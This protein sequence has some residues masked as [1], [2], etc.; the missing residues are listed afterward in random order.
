MIVEWLVYGVMVSALVSLAGWVAERGARAQ[1]WPTRWVWLGAMAAS[2]TVPLMAWLV[3]SAPSEPAGVAAP[4]TY[5]L[6]TLEPLRTA[7]AG[8]SGPSVGTLVLWVWAG[9]TTFVLLAVAVMAARL[10][11]RR[12]A[13]VA[14]SVDGVKVLVSRC[15]GPAALGLIRGRV[16]VPEWA[17][18]LEPG[19][20]RLLVLHE[21]EHVRAGDPRL[22]FVG[23]LLC[24][25]VPWNLPVW[26]QRRRLRLAIEV[27]CD[28][29]VLRRSGDARS[30][31]SLL[32]EVGQRRAGLALALAEPRSMLERRIRMITRRGKA[33][34]IRASV[35]GAVAGLVLAGACETPKPTE[36]NVDESVL[37]PGSTEPAAT[38]DSA[39]RLFRETQRIREARGTA[40][41]PPCDP[42]TYIDGARGVVGD[43]RPEEIESIS[44]FKGA[45]ARQA[46][47]SCGVILVLTKDATVA[48]RRAAEELTDRFRASREGREPPA[49]TEEE[50]Q[51]AAES[52]TAQE[53]QTREDLPAEP[54]FTPMTIHPQLR[55]RAVIAEA[56]RDYYPPLL[57]DAGIGGTTN[58][59]F[60]IDAEG[61][62]RKVRVNES[63]GHEAFDEAALAVGRLMEFEP[64]YNGEQRVAVWVALDIT[65][66]RE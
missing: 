64:A 18:S 51:P 48:E 27:D 36:T 8:S 21:A 65:F 38:H 5:L 34:T 16:V 35:L 66:A 20:R 31:G 54:T 59:W 24:A 44:V 3:P 9:A 39:F 43:L 28:A 42:T 63:S 40:E 14:R 58:V 19:R 45:G 55:N 30:Y 47:G 10:R 33:A 37:E 49:A 23:L 2:V 29:R 12:R 62:V 56:L 60:F 13:W 57:R 4:A 52:S 1:R 61:T 32:L 46:A 50:S 15:T 26:W 41:A 25:L 6:E 22:A 17:L 7:P 11:H 53:G